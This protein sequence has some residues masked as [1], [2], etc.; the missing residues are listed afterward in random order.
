M[1]DT[2][3]GALYTPPHFIFPTPCQVEVLIPTSQGGNQLRE[4]SQSAQ[5]DKAGKA[6]PIV[7][8]RWLDPKVESFQ[9]ASNLQH[10]PMRV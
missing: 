1:P 6:V 2:A 10:P 4:E 7:N 8:S 9:L 5:T 3:Q